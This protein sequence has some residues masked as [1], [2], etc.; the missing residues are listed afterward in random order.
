MSFIYYDLALLGIFVLFVFLFLYTHRENIKRQG[1]LYLYKTKFGIKFIDR[2]TTRFEKVLRPL[3]YVVIGSGI[4]LMISIVW[5]IV[6][7]TYIYMV[8]PIAEYVRAPPIAP[9]VPYFPKLFG[10]ESFFPP[11]YFTYFILAVAI[12]ALSHE[13]SHGIFARFYRFK[14]HSTGLAFLGPI[15][16]AFVEPD[17]KQ[18][19]KA[20][21]FPQMAV[22][23][24]GT[25]A[26][27]IM[28]LIFGLILWLF[29]TG[30][31]TPGGIK[32]NTYALTA[33]PLASIEINENTTLAE[34]FVLVSVDNKNFFVEREA[35]QKARENNVRSLLAY[36]DS[37]AFR[38]Q[39]R[40]AITSV[41]GTTI[42]TI[43]QLREI[44]ASHKPGDTLHV[45]TA[46][47]EEG[48]DKVKEQRSYSLTLTEREGKAFLGIGFIPIQARGIIGLFYTKVIA[49]IRDPNTYYE[50]TIGDIGLFVYYLLWWI[51]VINLLVAL[52]NMLPVSILDGGRFF[53]LAVWSLTKSEKVGRIAYKSTT[54]SI[55]AIV[56]LLMIRWI[57]A[58][59]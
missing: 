20:K 46:V 21:K 54:A 43:E 13:F 22:L 48:H 15:L 56:L 37:P 38:A 34:R 8:S 3:Q 16:G 19:T 30:L 39:L 31:F 24:A 55:L 12:V 18:M 1:I 4:V 11:L 40:G 25:F 2:F 42:T 41:D 36:D 10:L 29:F 28:V 52:F 51:V 14:I 33:I 44:L 5:L 53:Y 17:E 45:E 7:T 47:L 58:L 6:R 50:S 32:F 27:V 35:L 49:P 9:L 26:N 59:F 57:I 23:A